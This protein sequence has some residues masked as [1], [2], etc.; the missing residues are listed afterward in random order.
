MPVRL[1]L[2]VFGSLSTILGVLRSVMAM[3]RFYRSKA[4]KAKADRIIRKSESRLNAGRAGLKS[5]L[6]ALGKRKL[7]TLNGPLEDY[8]AAY[9][10]LSLNV[11]LRRDS[12]LIERP[13]N[14]CFPSV[15][16]ATMLTDSQLASPAAGL[17]LGGTAGGL[18][19][20]G[21][22]GASTA[23]ALAG[24]EA[25]ATCGGL[26]TAN[27]TLTWL[28]GGTLASGGLGL[29]V[30]GGVAVLGTLLVGPALLIFGTILGV[31]AAADLAKARSEIEKA[32][33]FQTLTKVFCRKMIR[34]GELAD[35]A[36]STIE[37]AT[38]NLTTATASLNRSI[39]RYGATE[40]APGTP[41]I[42]QPSGSAGPREEPV[43]SGN[44]GE[45]KAVERAL[46]SA[47]MTAQIVKKLIDAP[48]L[49]DTGDIAPGFESLCREQPL[50]PP[51]TE[52][53]PLTADCLLQ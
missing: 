9:R 2:V 34:I 11:E 39:D 37:R 22:Y 8:C 36:D 48:L 1:L 52:G 5:S 24:P 20:L 44:V 3:I 35:L 32:K 47:Y 51:P 19:T 14:C 26:A 42:P 28:G 15:Q 41:L 46:F 38:A 40:A 29:G 30:T 23:F 27:A 17:A 18:L 13:D 21:T 49:T 53:S 31:K 16:R 50:A 43:V 10:R 12:C 33:T 25:A 45:R 7:D 4:I 6:E